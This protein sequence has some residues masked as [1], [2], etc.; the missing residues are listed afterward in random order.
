MTSALLSLTAHQGHLTR[1]TQNLATA[2]SN[3]SPSA[4]A[5]AHAVNWLE[6]QLDRYIDSQMAAAVLCADEGQVALLDRRVDGAITAAEIQLGQAAKIN[7][8]K[9]STSSSTRWVINTPPSTPT[10]PGGIALPVTSG[11]PPT[12]TTL[13]TWRA[14]APRAHR[15]RPRSSRPTPRWSVSPACS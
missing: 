11:T 2:L 4:D 9:P 3:G 1:A 13:S 7:S 14:S 5:I 12:G 6:R 8:T 15:C 10:C